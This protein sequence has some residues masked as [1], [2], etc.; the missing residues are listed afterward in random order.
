MKKKNYLKMVILA[1]TFLFILP[2][3]SPAQMTSE[4]NQAIVSTHDFNLKV[5]VQFS[6]IELS[7]D[8]ILGYDLVTL[9]DGDHMNVIGRPMLPVKTIS[10]KD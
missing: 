4:Q 3:V 8:Q 2:I 1:V 7:F 5:M 10:K 6:D 9:K